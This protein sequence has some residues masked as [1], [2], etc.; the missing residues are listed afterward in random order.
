MDQ[1]CGVLSES[2]MIVSLI[3]NVPP[4]C[5]RIPGHLVHTLSS[6]YIYKIL[7]FRGIMLYVT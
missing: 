2:H 7:L 4:A 5:S 6:I 1:C 3:V